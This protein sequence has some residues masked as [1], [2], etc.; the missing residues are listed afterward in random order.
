VFEFLDQRSRQR[1]GLLR[2]SL[3]V[4]DVLPD[5]LVRRAGFSATA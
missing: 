2:R 3:E 1:R 4:N 5:S